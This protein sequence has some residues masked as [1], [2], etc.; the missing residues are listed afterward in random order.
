MK[1]ISSSRGFTRTAKLMHKLLQSQRRTKTQSNPSILLQT[2]HPFATATTDG[3]AKKTVFVSHSQNIFENLALEEWLYENVGLEERDYLLMWRN[4]PAVVIGRHQNPWTE[5]D[6]QAALRKGIAVVRRSSG[7]GTVYHDEGNLNLSFLKHRSRYDRRRNLS[8]VVDA[9]TSRWDLDLDLNCRDDLVLD[10]VYK[11]SGTASKLGRHR[12]YHHFTL[13]FDVNRD[14]LSSI[15]HSP[16]VGVDTRATKSVPSPVKNLTEDA[17]DMTFDT[18]VEVIG[19][20]FLQ[21]D[22]DSEEV[23]AVDPTDEGRFPGVTAIQRR[24]RS[25]EWVFGKTP[26]FSITRIF[27]QTVQDGSSAYAQYSLRTAVEIEKGRI[28]NISLTLSGRSRSGDEEV[29]VAFRL[30]DLVDL[31]GE[32]LEEGVMKGVWER[33]RARVREREGEEDYHLLCWGLEC[34][35][36]CVPVGR[37]ED[38]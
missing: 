18:L 2:A 6:V 38:L 14:V 29:E 35:M 30:L 3:K 11:V 23:T 7:G 10:G 34:L 25:W 22:D 28:H 8:L 17:P 12:T 5:C 37:V 31:V 24:L 20:R 9:V 4:T 26:P 16:M 13:V 36:K 32:K 15:L 27:A 1:L 33:C 19:Q 21:D